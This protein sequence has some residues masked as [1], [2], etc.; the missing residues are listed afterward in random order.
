[1]ITKFDN[2]LNESDEIRKRIEDRLKRMRS[3]YPNSDELKTELDSK[4]KPSDTKPIIKRELEIKPRTKVGT[5]VR[6]KEAFNGLKSMGFDE[7]DIKDYLDRI[8]E[9]YPETETGDIIMRG[10]RELSKK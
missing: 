5:D 6:K 1:M 10:I 3:L 4:P 7:K 8:V 2:F 9:L